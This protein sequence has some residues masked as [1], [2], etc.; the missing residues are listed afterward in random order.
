MSVAAKRLQET[1]EVWWSLTFP[2]PKVIP[3][4]IGCIHS[5][6]GI[7]DIENVSAA[8]HPQECLT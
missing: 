4:R 3:E 1:Y 2:D 7:I 6:R 8:I 5:P